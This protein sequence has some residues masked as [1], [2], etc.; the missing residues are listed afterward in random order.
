MNRGVAGWVVLIT[1]A[2]GPGASGEELTV[3]TAPPVVVK[4]DPQ[5]GSAGIDP[6]LTEIR[7][8]FSKE[9][10]TGGFSVVQESQE[11]MPKIRGKPR[12]AKDK[13]TLILPVE[14]EPGKDY[15]LWLNS[16]RYRNCKDADGRPAVP[17]L[18]GFQTKGKAAAAVP[19]PS[20][21]VLARAFDALCDDM[22]LHHSYFALKGVDWVKLQETYRPR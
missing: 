8:T 1:A 21:D 22:A 16:P 5:A 17:Y 12:Y 6:K 14:L 9:M 3:A 7:I 19:G 2:A 10:N 4:T 15:A 18:L 13:R 20:R 11:S